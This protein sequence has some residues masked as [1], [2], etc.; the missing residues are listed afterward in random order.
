MSNIFHNNDLTPEQALSGART[1]L[2]AIEAEEEESDRR[3]D[4]EFFAR[5]GITYQQWQSE[6]YRAAVAY[7]P[8]EADLADPDVDIY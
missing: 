8:S 2:L 5:Y 6:N 3:R 4:A 7:G 1:A